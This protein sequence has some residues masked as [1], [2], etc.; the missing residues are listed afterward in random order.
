M[1]RPPSIPPA[2]PAEPPTIEGSTYVPGSGIR[3]YHGEKPHIWQEYKLYRETGLRPIRG[4]PILG[5]GWKIFVIMLMLGLLIDYLLGIAFF[6]GI[7]PT[8]RGVFL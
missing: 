3:L 7:L 4:A 1:T 5:A 2:D 8:L 6:H